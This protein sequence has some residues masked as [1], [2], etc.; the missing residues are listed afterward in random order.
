LRRTADGWRIVEQSSWPLATHD[1]HG[2]RVYS[3]TLWAKLDAEAD[4]LAKTPG[5][6][7][8]RA[9]Q[10]A[11]RI[12]EAY[13]VAKRETEKPTATAE[14][15]VLRGDLAVTL[16]RPADGLADFAKARAKDPKIELPWYMAE[17]MPPAAPQ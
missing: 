17:P 2:P 16:G 12:A 11:K 8:I 9:L 5:A 15:W 10:D 4:A 3:P 13:A 14:L 6:A 1:E 7:Y